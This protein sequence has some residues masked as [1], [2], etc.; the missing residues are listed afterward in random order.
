MSDKG[1]FE[2]SKEGLK[3]LQEGKPKGFILRE[4]VQNAW[5]ENTKKCEV[6][7]SFK[8]GLAEIIVTDD[9]P[10]GFKDL[11]HAFTLFAPTTKRSNPE[12]RGRFN[13]G[14]KQILALCEHATIETTKG[15]IV[16]NSEGRLEFPGSRKEGSEITIHVKMTE[17]E[18]A[19]MLSTVQQYLIPEHIIFIVNK[20]RIP[21][22]KPFNSIYPTL[23]TEVSENGG[24]R[25]AQRKTKVDLHN[26]TGQAW[27]YEMGIPVT[28]IE[29]KYSL[30]VQQK[31]PLSMDRDTIP[32]SFLSA[33]YAEVLN[34][35]FSQI[36][37]EEA[38]EQWIREA[39]GNKRIQPEAVQEV[40]TKRFGEKVVVATPTDRNSIDEAISQGYRV[41]HGSELS[42]EEWAAVKR[43]EII[44]SSSEL[45]GLTQAKATPYEADR[46][47]LAFADFA[48]RV[49]N[50]HYH[51]NIRVEF[52]EWDG[53]VLATY[54][55]GLLTFNVKG[56]GKDY[57]KNGLTPQA[58]GLLIHEL[59]H[60]QGNHTEHSYHE[61]L[62]N[63]A[64]TLI[65]KA[66]KDPTFFKLKDN[67]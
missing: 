34:V 36:T 24:L 58:L 5:D 20:T 25:K 67:T 62:T 16:F 50:E 15:T 1:W 14:E 53:T 28:Q 13:L 10:E 35:T 38:S 49:A 47:M 59:G 33:L 46:N 56:L 32:L 12:K 26:P 9:N 48:K 42:K 11:T 61:A 44:P 55:P 19:E 23:P 60:E 30:D 41:V 6:T 40:I 39:T 45:F 7:A 8:D 66:I 54:S 4:L 43:T 21:Y 51:I 57:F 2:V 18:Y 27:L 64:A 3:E 37:P 52:K 22:K 31:I 17:A 63:M 65:L 29:C